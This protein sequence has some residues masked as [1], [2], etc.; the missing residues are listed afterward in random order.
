MIIQ[1]LH[2]L[3][4]SALPDIHATRFKA[5]MAA[6][7]A[8]LSGTSVSITGLGRAVSGTIPIKHKIKRMDRLVG[9]PHLNG[10]RRAIYGVMAQWLLRSLPMPLILCDWSPLTDDQSQQLLRASLP[11]G[12]RS[13]T[14]YEEVHPR[15]KLGNRHVQQQFLERLRQWLPPQAT[16]I[17]VADSG[18]RTPFFRAAEGFG[19]HW[20]GRIRNRDFI[21]FDDHPEDWLPAKSLY[22]EASRQPKRL[23]SVRW[24]RSHPLAGQLVT[25]FRLPKGRKHQTLRKRPAKSRYSRKQ[26]AREKEPWLLV[27]SPSL[28]AYSPVRIVDYY[29]CRM[30]IEEGFRDTK[31]THYDLALADESRIRSERR[32][33]LLLIVFALWIVGV[34]L[35]GTEIEHHIKVNSGPKSPYSAIFL[36]RIACRYVVFELPSDYLALAQALLI[37]YFDTLEMG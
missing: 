35:K 3:L 9:N 31:A 27:V 8:G 23:G 10:E 2:A 17:V 13:L 36:A 25:F 7:K 6:V 11:V 12:G 15:A 22:A 26:A 34:N 30:Q 24:V 14:L 5:L 32:A 19:W 20:L 21:A 1:A 18:F 33:N 4:K 29:R 37:G 28:K 16:P